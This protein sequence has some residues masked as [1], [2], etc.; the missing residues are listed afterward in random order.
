MPDRITRRFAPTLSLCVG[1]TAASL[2]WLAPVTLTPVASAAVTSVTPYSVTSAKGDL[3]V[4]SGAGSVWYAVATVKPG[5]PLRVDA[6]S[7]GWLRVQYL[8]GM[9]AVV[10][11][12]DAERRADGSV[13]LTRPS[14]LSCLDMS[15]PYME[16]CYKALLDERL[17]VGT[18]LKYVGD[19]ADR[20]GKVDGFRVE[21]PSSARGWVFAADTKKLS[22]A[23]AAKLAG[24][25][26]AVS[27]GAAG[28]PAQATPAPTPAPTQAPA[29]TPTPA[30]TQT[31]SQSPTPTP[32]PAG[33]A[34]P[35]PA[36]TT[37]AAPAEGTPPTVTTGE[38]QPGATPTTTDP[39]PVEATPVE[40][41]KP[42]EP[43]PEEI[44]AREIA[45]KMKAQSERLR[46][47]DDAFN[48]VTS[49]PVESAEIEPL[50]GEYE[51][52]KAD[53][54]SEPMNARQV[55]YV[56]N[57]IDLLRLR[58]DLQGKYRRM[59][60][61]K[62]QTDQAISG[63]M[64]RIE[65]IQR[66]KQYLVVG[67]LTVSQMYDGARLPRLYRVQSIDTNVSRTLAYLTPETNQQLEM[68]LGMIVGVK[69]DGPYDPS[70][71]V[72]ILVP[73]QVDILRNEDGTPMSAPAGS[74]N[75]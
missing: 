54:G 75:P 69:G 37:A 31:P 42:R 17:P 52:F 60:E 8:P 10:K 28:K 23:D 36:P 46:Q 66:S 32:A 22:D 62:A 61:L 14:A 51:K 21:A 65:R 13:V 38:P 74:T 44:R 47:L 39:A 5:T 33:G 70:A 72:N 24:A 35:V 20:S 45:A 3:R 11:S 7:E 4:R 6:E 40:P 18:V 49:Q 9:V 67:R 15:D 68:K 30:P 34:E 29:P 50:I 16:A 19:V 1:L 27:Q 26:P 59:A 43:T 58:V 71:K 12:S 41:P 57:R 53:L 2:A 25:A 63:I 64:S 73:T 48:V 56:N 55:V